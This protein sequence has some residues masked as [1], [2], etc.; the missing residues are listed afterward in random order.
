M[1]MGGQYSL[2]SWVSLSFVVVSVRS[3]TCFLDV[4]FAQY[5]YGVYLGINGALVSRGLMYV[6][7]FSERLYNSS[8][9]SCADRITVGTSAAT[10]RRIYCVT[11]RF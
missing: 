2:F 8:A 9:F 6:I 4:R 7:C 3:L 5:M 10:L 11:V 1:F